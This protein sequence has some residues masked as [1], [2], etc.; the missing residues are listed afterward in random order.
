MTEAQEL[1]E[2]HLR[3]TV[4]TRVGFLVAD[5]VIVPSDKRTDDSE[6]RLE[7]SPERQRLLLAEKIRK[8]RLKFEMKIKRAVEKTRTRT[9]R[10]ALLQRLDPSLND[11]GTG[12]ESEVVVRAEHNTTTPFHNHLD[13]LS[14][15]EPVEI[16]IDPSPTRH[17]RA[18]VLLAF[19]EKWFHASSPLDP[20]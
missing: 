12:R 10:S 16:R 2:T 3:G 17:I 5:E 11:F 9:A 6:I 8:F 7:A 1:A 19:M 15:L 13:V 14:R 4:D 20:G 18:S